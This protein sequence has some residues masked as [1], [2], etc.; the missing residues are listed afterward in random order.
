MARK[1][2]LL[3]NTGDIQ[4]YAHFNDFDGEFILDPHM[5]DQVVRGILDQ[6]KADRRE[7]HNPRAQGRHVARIPTLWY[8]TWKKEWKSGA[9]QD[10]T[11]QQFLVAKLNLSENAHLKTGV[12]VA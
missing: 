10:V 3:D 12:K 9:N 8:Q 4:T 5:P 7:G 2:L 11:W 1:K 6:N